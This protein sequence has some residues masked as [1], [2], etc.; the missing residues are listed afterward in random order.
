MY[1]VSCRGLVHLGGLV[2]GFPIK[3]E[4]MEMTFVSSCFAFKKRNKAIPVWVWALCLAH[5]NKK[6]FLVSNANMG[7]CLYMSSTSLVFNTSIQYLRISETVWILPIKF[8]YF[9]HF[10]IF[11][12]VFAN[13]WCQ[14]KVCLSLLLESVRAVLPYHS[15]NHTRLDYFKV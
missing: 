7:L 3:A 9:N 14:L 5:L 1:I 10:W 2:R 12:F 13:N 6:R 8:C 4:K 11:N 15:F